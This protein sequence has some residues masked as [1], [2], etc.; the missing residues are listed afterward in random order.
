MPYTSANGYMFSLLNKDGELG[1]RLP[2]ELQM[3]FIEQ[4]GGGELRSYGAVMRDYVRIPN[5]LLGNTEVLG[6][7]LQLSYEYVMKLPPK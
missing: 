7:Y 4:Y 3:E 2:K 6:K 1:F 5:E